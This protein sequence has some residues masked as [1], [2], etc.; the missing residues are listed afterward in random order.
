[1]VDEPLPTDRASSAPADG[2]LAPTTGRVDGALPRARTLW[3]L[4]VVAM[5]LDVALTDVGLSLGL[6]ERNRLARALID[7]VG[8]LGAG[9]VLKGAG[10]A[11]AYACWRLLPRLVPGGERYRRLV[12]A[13]A[14]APSLVA[15]G[16]NAVLILS[17][18]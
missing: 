11:V 5:A 16:V 18:R 12:P 8:L 7:A 1:M 10:L 13:A 3:A 6:T 2:V 4:A 17:V 15:A 9:V 14:G